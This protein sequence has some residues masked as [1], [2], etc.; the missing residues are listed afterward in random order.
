MTSIKG[1]YE[2]GPRGFAAKLATRYKDWNRHY[3]GYDD[4]DVAELAKVL[5]PVLAK[6]R[7]GSD[8]EET[9]IELYY[10]VEGPAQSASREAIS[11]WLPSVL[12]YVAGKDPPALGDD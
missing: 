7:A 5:E 2:S 8:P 12:A 4:I 1:L 10:A 6:H 9:A 11:F 3:T